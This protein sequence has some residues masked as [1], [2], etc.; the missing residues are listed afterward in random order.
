MNMAQPDNPPHPED[1]RRSDLLLV[2]GEALQVFEDELRTVADI[3]VDLR[4]VFESAAQKLANQDRGEPSGFHLFTCFSLM[5]ASELL[6]DDDDRAPYWPV[7]WLAENIS[8]MAGE[9][10]LWRE[11]E[12]ILNGIGDDP[13]AGG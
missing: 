3:G 6:F 4:A 2:V 1:I 8:K 7:R 13:A 9:V 12:A 10:D 11:V 5:A